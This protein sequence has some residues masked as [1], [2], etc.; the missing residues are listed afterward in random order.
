MKDQNG[1]GKITTAS[2]LVGLA[3]G[4]ILLGFLILTKESS[5]G[6]Q[7]AGG[8]VGILLGSVFLI[9]AFSYWRIE[10]SNRE[11]AFMP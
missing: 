5:Q 9:S 11:N 7:I 6:P 3:L 10:R 1:L 8:V 2:S 4:F